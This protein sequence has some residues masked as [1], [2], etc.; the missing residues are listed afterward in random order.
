[1]AVVAANKPSMGGVSG[2][3]ATVVSGNK[4]LGGAVPNACMAGRID[5]SGNIV[6]SLGAAANDAGAVHGIIPRSGI[7]GEPGALYGVGTVFTW[8]ASGGLTPG[9]RYYLAAAGGVDDASTL[10]DTTGIFVAVSTTE[11]MLVQLKGI[12]G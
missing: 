9:N 1:M 8:D 10:G 7:A 12:G 3:K 2:Q 4:F 5:G 6:I 11:L